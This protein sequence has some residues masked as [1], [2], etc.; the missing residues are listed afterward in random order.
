MIIVRMNAWLWAAIAWI[1]VIFFSSTTLAGESSQEAFSA[2]SQLLMKNLQPGTSSYN[3]ID[4]LADKSVHIGL[5]FVFAIL[6]WRA[7]PNVSRKLVCILLIGAVIGSCSE[8]L[9][10]F[11]PGRD[12]AIRDVLINIAGT[13]LGLV[14]S[15]AISKVRHVP[16]ESQAIRSGHGES[17][18]D[19]DWHKLERK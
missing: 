10:M 11:F 17:H 13:G 8:L 1:G 15:V 16:L 5:F 7:L 9:Q 14:F 19:Q 12:P 18:Y 4:L 6:L 2:L 3:L